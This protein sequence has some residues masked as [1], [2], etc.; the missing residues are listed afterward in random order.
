MHWS[1]LG[2]LAVQALLDVCGF[3]TRAGAGSAAGMPGGVG[4]APSTQLRA[5]QLLA[6]ALLAKLRTTVKV[7][8]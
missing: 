2:L 3:E 1:S 5:D 6:P 8:V 4:I 7:C